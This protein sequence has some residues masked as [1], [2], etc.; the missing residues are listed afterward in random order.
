MSYIGELHLDPTA[1][2]D[3][4]TALSIKVLVITE[5]YQNQFVVSMPA[6]TVGAIVFLAADTSRASAILFPSLEE[7]ARYLITKFGLRT[8]SIELRADRS[9]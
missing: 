8:F 6:E 5:R 3:R 4:L 1:F 2:Q 9:R 7:C